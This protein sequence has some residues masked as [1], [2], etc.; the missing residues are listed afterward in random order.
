MKWIPV[1]ERNPNKT[2]SQKLLLITHEGVVSPAYFIDKNYFEI[3]EGEPI[4][5]VQA[6]MPLPSPYEE[7]HLL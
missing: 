6:W 1:T 3:Y 4:F 5:E 7:W 2:E